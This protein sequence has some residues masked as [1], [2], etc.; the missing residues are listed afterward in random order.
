MTMALPSDSSMPELSLFDLYDKE[1]RAVDVKKV[2]TENRPTIEAVDFLELGALIMNRSKFEANKKSFEDRWTAH[3]QAKPLVIAE[4]WRLL[5]EA[6]D[7]RGHPAHLLWAF[8]WAKTYA[9]EKVC[10]GLCGD[11]GD[12]VHE[13]TFRDWA[14]YDI[15]KVSWLEFELVSCSIDLFASWQCTYVLIHSLCSSDL[16]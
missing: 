16:F 6:G 11:D 12:P 5:E 4:I 10:A 1:E 14:W 15:E 8:L 9:T 7:N 13:D 2:K 3:F